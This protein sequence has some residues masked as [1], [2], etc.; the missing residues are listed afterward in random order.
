MLVILQQG[1]VT[2]ADGERD[3]DARQSGG[4]G[5]ASQAKR[6][7]LFVSDDLMKSDIVGHHLAPGLV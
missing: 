1:A 4:P 6:L 7:T 3:F 5:A 2:G